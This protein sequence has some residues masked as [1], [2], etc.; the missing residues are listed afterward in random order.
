MGT[1]ET[2]SAG[3]LQSK[4]GPEGTPSG[5]VRIGVTVRDGKRSLT[6]AAPIG[7]APLHFCAAH[8]PRRGA[9]LVAPVTGCDGSFGFAPR[10]IGLAMQRIRQCA[11]MT[12]GS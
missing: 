5:S 4:P 2:F 6:V 11:I 9:A 10:R 8:R 3:V 12:V 1:T 7:S